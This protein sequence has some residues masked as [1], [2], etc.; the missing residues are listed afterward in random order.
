MYYIAFIAA[1]LIFIAICISPFAIKI[2]FKI[3]YFK[4]L[5]SGI[6]CV[7]LCIIAFIASYVLVAVL[8]D[9][10]MKSHG[11]SYYNIP[12]TFTFYEWINIQESN[13]LKNLDFST[14]S[15]YYLVSYLILDFVI[16]VLLILFIMKLKN[17]I[18]S[19]KQIF[20]FIS[21]FIIGFELP[22]GLSMLISLGKI[23]DGDN[24]EKNNRFDE[25]NQL[26][27]SFEYFVF[28][29]LSQI[30]GVILLIFFWLYNKKVLYLI[31]ALL[32]FFLPFLL[33]Y[34]SLACKSRIMSDFITELT[35]YAALV[36][37]IIFYLKDNNDIPQEAKLLSS[38]SQN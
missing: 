11:F 26:L 6:C 16:F 17:N 20:M 5:C 37:G 31:L 7:I 32:S 29:Y 18:E 36:L 30:I 22:F 14:F 19:K 27:L 28:S 3:Q 23:G 33:L 35:Y 12:F 10:F 15:Y 1:L 4:G 38:S 25:Y 8:M 13:P 24:Y 9:N 34:I 21:G 2:L